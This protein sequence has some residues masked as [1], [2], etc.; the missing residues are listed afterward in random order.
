MFTFYFGL[1]GDGEAVQ[2][3][4]RMRTGP[5]AK[6]RTTTRPLSRALHK[7]GFKGFVTRAAPGRPPR[8]LRGHSRGLRGPPG[9]LWDLRQTKAKKPR[10]L[11]DLTDQSNMETWTPRAR[12]M[13]PSHP[14]RGQRSGLV[15]PEPWVTGPE[16]CTPPLRRPG[17]GRGPGVDFSLVFLW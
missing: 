12:M 2:R 11:K 15:K 16:F 7:Y 14:G 8:A 17:S 5:I 3:L 1:Q 9:I 6:A 10:N 4:P 13:Q